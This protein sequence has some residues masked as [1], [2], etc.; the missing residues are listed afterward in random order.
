MAYYREQFLIEVDKFQDEW[1]AIRAAE[2]QREH[3]RENR[4]HELRSTF[5]NGIGYTIAGLIVAAVA[6]GII[7]FIWSGAQRG[8]ERGL[9]EEKEQTK[10]LQ[11][12]MD[13][14]QPAERQL[15]IIG[16]VHEEEE[17]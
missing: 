6:I 5:L 12:C 11:A 4:R 9:A 17:E 7:Y 2:L 15:C 13:L 3:T 1:A 14:E 10:Q 8:G 16:L